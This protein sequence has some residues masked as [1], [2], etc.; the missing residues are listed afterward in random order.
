MERFL[1]QA[2]SSFEV[3]MKTFKEFKVQEEFYL[4]VLTLSL[5]PHSTDNNDDSSNHTEKSWVN[6]FFLFDHINEILIIHKLKIN[7]GNT[8]TIQYLV[9]CLLYPFQKGTWCPTSSH[10]SFPP[11]TATKVRKKC[12]STGRGSHRPN[13]SSHANADCDPTRDLRPEVLLSIHQRRA[14]T[15][16]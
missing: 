10:V 5:N 8:I 2:S 14:V 15:P 12:L 6:P 9:E 7:L 4:A 3:L 13:T 11:N 1:H 16:H